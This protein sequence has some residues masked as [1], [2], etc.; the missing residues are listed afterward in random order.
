MELMQA[1]SPARFAASSSTE[2]AAGEASGTAAGTRECWQR[3]HLRGCLWCVA[4][5]FVQLQPSSGS[6]AVSE[7][8]GSASATLLACLP[9]A[10]GLAAGAAAFEARLRVRRLDVAAA[11]FDAGAAPSL[12]QGP[13]PRS[14][15]NIAVCWALLSAAPLPRHLFKISTTLDEASPL[16]TSP[17]RRGKTPLASAQLA[18]DVPNFFSDREPRLRRPDGCH[19]MPRCT[20]EGLCT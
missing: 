13:A 18:K 11:S 14:W 6:T 20:D 10:A 4:V 7:G 9:G 19:S 2:S 8:S 1:C 12:P 16:A 3:R 15:P 5:Q 17:A